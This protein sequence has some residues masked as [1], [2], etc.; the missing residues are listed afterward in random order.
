MQWALVRAPIDAGRVAHLAKGFYVRYP[1]GMIS[2]VKGDHARVLDQLPADV[3]EA[4]VITVAE[5]D[6]TELQNRLKGVVRDLRAE[7]RAGSR[8]AE[9]LENS[10]AA[11]EADYNVRCLG[12]FTQRWFGLADSWRTRDPDERTPSFLLFDIAALLE[13]TTTRIRK[14]R[15]DLS[16]DG[17]LSANIQLICDVS[18]KVAATQPF[19]SERHFME[20]FTY[21]NFIL[22]PSAIPHDR[23]GL[24]ICTRAARNGHVDLLRRMAEGYAA[25]G[26]REIE[27]A[28]NSTG[29]EVFQSA[30]FRAV[31]PELMASYVCAGVLASGAVPSQREELPW[32][33]L[34]INCEERL[35]RMQR[36]FLNGVE[37]V[38][39]GAALMRHTFLIARLPE[40]EGRKRAAELVENQ[41]LYPRDFVSHFTRRPVTNDGP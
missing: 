14:A 33:G 40:A 39:A 18:R 25:I 22:F 30:L 36:S 16:A 28:L 26:R 17:V 3:D 20:W 2:H 6:S 38:P 21:L 13:Q 4:S 10:L 19:G 23:L 1:G 37:D 5:S 41:L 7:G 31:V 34:R 24:V 12:D 15:Q 35:A 8:S 29:A 27:R 9:R 32:R 11:C